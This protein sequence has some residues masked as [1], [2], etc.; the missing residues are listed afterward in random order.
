MKINSALDVMAST[1]DNCG[2]EAT[3]IPNSHQKVMKSPKKPRPATKSETIWLPACAP[4]A[5]GE[6]KLAK[7][8]LRKKIPAKGLPESTLF[9]GDCEKLLD[10]WIA[11][12]TEPFF[13]VFT[14]MVSMMGGLVSVFQFLGI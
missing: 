3:K 1:E 10:H 14:L 11:T 13:E 2:H 4:D 5:A 8:L 7:A 6:Q 12:T 9:Q